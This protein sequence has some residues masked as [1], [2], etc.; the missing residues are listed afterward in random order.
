MKKQLIV[1]AL[2]IVSFLNVKAQDGG[3]YLIT[4]EGEKVTI[5]GDASLSTEWISFRDNNGKML[6]YKHKNIKFLTINNRIF[7]TLQLMGGKMMRLEEVVCFNDKYILTSFY[8]NGDY[9]ILVYNWDFKLVQPHKSLSPYKKKQEADIEKYVTPYFPTCAK[10]YEVM[11][12]NIA[13]E[14]TEKIYEDG[15]YRKVYKIRSMLD[16]VYA[17][18]CGGTKTL[19]DMVKAF[20]A[21]S[22]PVPEGKK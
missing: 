21:W 4:K 20:M 11:A 17:V 9:S 15:H 8:Q 5:L 14:E 3:N 1:L 7:F 10:A 12:K 19:S 18:S 6:D 2:L 16:N 13:D 22:P